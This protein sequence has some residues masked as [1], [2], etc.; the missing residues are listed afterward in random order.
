MKWTEQDLASR[1]KGDPEKV[2]LPSEMKTQTT[3]LV[4]W[5]AQWLNLGYCGCLTWRLYHEP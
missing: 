5:I 2:R 1:Q 4:P 3:M